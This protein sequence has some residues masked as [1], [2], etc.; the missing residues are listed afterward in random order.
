MASSVAAGIASGAELG[1]KVSDLC[2]DPLEEEAV[3]ADAVAIDM[4]GNARG[5]PSRADRWVY[6]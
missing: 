6:A 2:S 1:F 5:V 3:E 4:L